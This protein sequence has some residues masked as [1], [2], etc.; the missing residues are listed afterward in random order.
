MRRREIA[1]IQAALRDFQWARGVHWMIVEPTEDQYGEDAVDVIVVVADSSPSAQ[2]WR[3]TRARMRALI[4]DA[5]DRHDILAR[6]FVSFRTESEQ[7]ALPSVDVD[8]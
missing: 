7:K 3:E 6:P 1:R 5:F 4:R 8:M 2:R